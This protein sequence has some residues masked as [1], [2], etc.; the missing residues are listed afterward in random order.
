MLTSN[1]ELREKTFEDVMKLFDKLE[2]IACAHEKLIALN[3]L[4]QEYKRGPFEYRTFM[5]DK[6]SC[7]QLLVD[8]FN[9]EIEKYV[10]GEDK[11]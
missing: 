11:R 7:E 8:A 4:E 10:R 6:E 1:V 3:K 9:Y 5:G 2:T